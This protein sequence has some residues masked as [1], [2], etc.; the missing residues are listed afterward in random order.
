MTGFRQRVFVWRDIMT[1]STLETPEQVMTHAIE[2]RLSKHALASL[3]T[4]Q[5]R[6]GFLAACAT[7][8]QQ[9]TEDCQAL[10][11]PCLE[12]GCSMEDERCLQPLLRA[13]TDYYK[14]CGAEWATIF[15]DGGNRDASW[16]VTLSE[17][18]LR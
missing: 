16:K 12:S 13:G 5:A 2:G 3:L 7:I 18:D 10:N 8:E 14:A 9:Y 1:A 11:D 4:A 15:A 17:Y 6:R